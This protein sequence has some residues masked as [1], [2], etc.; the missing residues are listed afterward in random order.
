MTIPHTVVIK[1]MVFCA[2]DK[3]KLSY[4]AYTVFTLKSRDFPQIRATEDM[5]RRGY[6]AEVLLIET[7]KAD[8]L[9]ALRLQQSE[10]AKERVEKSMEEVG[11]A[12]DKLNNTK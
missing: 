1:F 3:K 11:D 12:D 5:A 7:D 9:A 10:Y 4:G 2:V 8:N 6:P